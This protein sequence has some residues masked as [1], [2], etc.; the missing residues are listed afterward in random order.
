MIENVVYNIV[1]TFRVYLALVEGLEAIF[2]LFVLL[3]CMFFR[4]V[5]RKT[6]NPDFTVTVNSEFFLQFTFGHR[7]LTTSLTNKLY[8]TAAV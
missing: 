2:E 6:Y 8:M 1:K 5:P 3:S 7:H 4:S